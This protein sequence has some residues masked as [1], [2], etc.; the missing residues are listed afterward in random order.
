MY[1][2]RFRINCNGP[3]TQSV[4]LEVLGFRVEGMWTPETMKVGYLDP[5]G[6][7]T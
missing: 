6:M 1:K 7:H 3:S 4:G 2:M 5:Q